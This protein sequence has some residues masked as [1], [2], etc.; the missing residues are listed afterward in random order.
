MH[1]LGEVNERSIEEHE[2]VIF[3][4]AH[5]RSEEQRGDALLVNPGE[6][7]GWLYGV[8]SAAILDLETLMVEWVTLDDPKWKN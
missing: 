3:G 8:P 5:Q 1:D 7:C 4:F 6:A 2:I